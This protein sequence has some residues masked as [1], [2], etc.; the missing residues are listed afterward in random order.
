MGA[1][2]VMP[3][4]E[5]PKPVGAE[6]VVLLANGIRDALTKHGLFDEE[7]CPP[8]YAERQTKAAL[9]RMFRT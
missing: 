4:K 3:S 6:D 7:H 5:S 1:G 8:I 2:K 9:A